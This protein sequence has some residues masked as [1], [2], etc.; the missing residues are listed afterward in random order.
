MAEATQEQ[1]LLGVGSS[2]MFGAGYLSEDYGKLVCQPYPLERLATSA[3]SPFSGMP[4][5][6]VLGL[7]LWS[8]PGCGD[9]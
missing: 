2:A 7:P 9:E 5:A 8:R 1:K 6:T 3:F 4:D